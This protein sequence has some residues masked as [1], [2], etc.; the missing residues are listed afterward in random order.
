MVTC[1][2]AEFLLEYSRDVPFPPFLV[3]MKLRRCRLLSF[4]HLCLGASP[5][6][7]SSI[8]VDISLWDVHVCNFVCNF[9]GAKAGLEGEATPQFNY[10]SVQKTMHVLSSS[11]QNQ[12]VANVKHSPLSYKIFH[13]AVDESYLGVISSTPARTEVPNSH[14]ILLKKGCLVD[15]HSTVWFQSNCTFPSK[16]RLHIPAE[17]FRYITDRG[18]E[19][20]EQHVSLS[21]K[22]FP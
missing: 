3:R 4:S 5:D 10:N 15:T 16:S 13:K 21:L 6:Y 8:V 12:S 20:R 9:L 19:K 18:T 17:H 22:K 7:F 11:S 1:L 2:R 14:N